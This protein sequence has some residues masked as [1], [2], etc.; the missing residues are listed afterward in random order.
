MA[1]IS[2]S[3]VGSGLDIDTLVTDL[4]N[5]EKEPAET[6][7]TLRETEAQTQLSAFGILKSALADFRSSL[8]GLKTVASVSGRTAISANPELFTASADT[9]A[10]SGRYAIEVVRLAEAHKVISNEFTGGA[11]H[12]VGVG[13]LT[14]TAGSKS[15]SVTIDENSDTLADIR[16]AINNAQ[17]DSGVTASIINVDG[18]GGETV[19]KLVLTADKTGEDNRLKVTVVDNDGT[20]TD[21][22]GLSQLA[23]DPGAGVEQLTQVQQ[24]GTDLDAEI[25]VDGQS[26]TRASNSFDSVIEGVTITA[27]QTSDVDTSDDLT[28]AR[29]ENDMR[30]K[31][32]EFIDAFNSLASTFNDLASY[33]ANSGQTG[34]LFADTTLQRIESQIRRTLAG[35]VDNLPSGVNS[36]A[37]V[38]MTTNA[39]GFLR[40]GIPDGAGSV[41]SSRFD[42]VLEE[43]LDDLAELFAGEEG[44]ANRLD[45]LI[46]PY[47][48]SAGVIQA[49]TDGLDQNILR[50]GEDREFLDRRMVSLE[51]R[52]MQQFIT[53]DALVAQLRTTGDFLTQQLDG[54]RA[55]TNREK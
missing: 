9:D 27:L 38:G 45:D 28:I 50:I 46:D 51:D 35:A 11:S 34:V 10:E 29:D 12:E 1:S 32:N 17:D 4:V 33:D 21:D 2:I 49:R 40:M 36:L 3:G 25:K 43:N 8:D 6:R 37:A 18:A 7:L 44:V 41:D 19:S 42:A 53:M 54:L 31:V 5:T 13:E 55:L 15:F 24:P 47:L 16:D 26:V 52:L 23:Y 30:D 14:I 20:H 48:S 22:A 39:Q